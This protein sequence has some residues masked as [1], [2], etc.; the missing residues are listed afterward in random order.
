MSTMRRSR[1][2]ITLSQDLLQQTDRLIDHN[3]IRNRSHA[4]EYV[5]SQYFQPT[6]K[7]A[8]ILAGGQGTHLRP[9][10]YEI[11]KSLLPVKGKPILEH[12]LR[13]LKKSN[14][15]DIYLCVGYLGDKIKEH[16]G[17]GDKL[18][19]RITYLE[20]KEPLHTGG[21]LLQA[22]PYVEESPFL[23]IHGD[24]LT[25]FSF[26]E[27]ID[28]H[29]K[30]S[31]LVSAALTSVDKPASYGQLKLHGTKLVGFY[32]HSESA[33]IQSYLVNTGIYVCDPGIYAFFPKN[34]KS[35]LFED[36]I[37]QLIGQK[38]VSGFVFEGQWYDVGDPDNYERAIKHFRGR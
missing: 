18:G 13:D 30:E 16:F 9:Y 14:I 29:Q 37:Q 8:V 34:K 2:T 38:K 15:T 5:L 7:K 12:L 4:I 3:K 11:P 27:L 26:R 1:I 33:D 35:F 32:Q 17:T 10:T 6:I 21:A 22:K 28:F 19:V 36:V 31:S 23:V 20:E 24:I 25:D